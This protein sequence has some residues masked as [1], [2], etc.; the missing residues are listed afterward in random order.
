[1]CG[2]TIPQILSRF[3]AP[4]L[5]EHQG[6]PAPGTG[7]NCRGPRL[8]DSSPEDSTLE[9]PGYSLD[10][11]RRD[12][13]PGETNP[14]WSPRPSNRQ[15]PNPRRTNPSRSRQCREA[16]REN[17]AQI[18]SEFAARYF[19]A[20]RTAPTATSGSQLGISTPATRND[21]DSSPPPLVAGAGAGAATGAG[22]TR[23]T[24]MAV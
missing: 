6:H 11:P 7:C 8:D 3:P 19:L 22:I 23:N 17:P 2:L 16:R 1:M 15:T 24:V 12:Q 4:L 21:P 18:V 20:T 5:P 9:A 10:S 13:L 14:S